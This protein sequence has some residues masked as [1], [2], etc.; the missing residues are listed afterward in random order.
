MV[1]R[2][3][4]IRIHLGENPLQQI[5][6]RRPGPDRGLHPLPFDGPYEEI[7]TETGLRLYRPGEGEARCWRGPLP[8]AGE[9]PPLDPTL[10]L[11][12]DGDIRWGFEADGRD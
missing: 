12:R 8:C 7:V 11:R 4:L 10:R 3:A 9:W 6:V 1:Y 2:A 5:P